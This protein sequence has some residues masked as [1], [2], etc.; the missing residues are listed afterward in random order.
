LSAAGDP[1]AALTGDAGRPGRV[2]PADTAPTPNGT[3]PV[4]AAC[5]AS[6]FL[7]ALLLFLVQPMVARL[8]LPGYGGSPAVWS[9][10]LVFYQVVLLAGYAYA[11]LATTRLSGRLR[12]GLHLGVVLVG[13]LVLPPAARLAAA[14][15]AG[16][17][18][19]P[20]VLLALAAAIGPPFFALSS[21]ATLVQ[22]WLAGSGSAGAR[23]PY[24]LYAASNAGSLLALVAYPLLLEPRL[25]LRDQGGSWSVGYGLFV[26]LTL[27]VLRL[28]WPAPALADAATV[29]GADAGEDPS[30][31]AAAA[32][33]PT[34]R[35]RLGWLVRAAVPVSLMLAVTLTLSTDVIALPLLWV[36]PLAVYLLT[37]ILAFALPERLPR[38]P[39]AAATVTSILIDLVAQL[40]P[41]PLPM[42]VLI[43]VNLAPLAA[44]GLLCHLDLARDR[45][46]PRFLTGFYLWLALGGAL[47]GIANSLLAPL[48]FD[49][50]A[51]YPL[52]L[53]ALAWLV[54]AAGPRAMGQALAASW[55]RGA[56][57][58][59]TILA[60]GLVSTILLV[61][62]D[63]SLRTWAVILLALLLPYSL[64]FRPR[65]AHFALAG[66]LVAVLLGLGWASVLP[67]MAQDR[68]FFGV[69]RVLSE[70]G[71]RVMIHG[72]TLH[73][74]QQE[75]PELARIPAAYYH[76]N[77][78]LGRAVRSMPA[79]AR[80]GLV[81]LGTGALAAL[82]QPGQRAD[83]FE[84]DPLVVDIARS[85]FT[86]LRDAPGEVAV[87]VADGRLGLA[88]VPDG[89]YD[90]LVLDAFSSDAVP[91][92]LLT[93]EALDLYR[94]KVRPGGLIVVHVSNRELDLA[95]V[96]RGWSAAT[97]HPVA[98]QRWEPATA[99]RQQGAVPTVAV[100]LAPEDATVRRLVDDSGGAWQL[101]DPTGPAATWTDDRSDLM[102]VLS[103]PWW[104]TLAGP[105]AGPG[106][107]D[108]R[109]EGP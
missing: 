86:Y 103:R 37:Y 72:T 34:R 54:G 106:E 5:V 59:L 19:V 77:G 60:V 80:I 52:T 26:V 102:G 16:A 38:G 53:A 10:A 11:H 18:P 83:F 98:L 50:V 78:P 81:G 70:A 65:Q 35:R 107:G 49:N 92:H 24:R 90:L 6:V 96:F 21:N 44:G 36:L 17:W 68:S 104:P 30:A 47:G 63:L 7:S 76:P 2:E 31:A 58:T 109:D 29:V 84:I 15:P 69:V 41:L 8:L 108:G 101:L 62:G 42:P 23:D 57:A 43:A 85:A 87:T 79:D 51:E 28:T 56:P 25:G 4:L 100:A 27:V 61:R 95:R 13:L 67:V 94:R 14:P 32:T 20:W 93:A 73:G 66:T 89:H 45:P 33:A 39:I 74:V 46:A 64:V 40:V 1:T 75:D 9:T 12:V 3:W 105:A 91:T 82:T 55:R 97:G 99:D 22:R 48:V 71:A 88:A